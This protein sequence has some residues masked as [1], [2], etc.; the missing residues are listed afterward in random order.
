MAKNV[1]LYGGS[2][3]PV[4]KAHEAIA[5][6]ALEMVQSMTGEEHELWFL[7]AY[8]DAFSV[9]RYASAHHRLNML[10]IITDKIVMMNRIRV[11]SFEIDMANKAGTYAVVNALM[12]EYPSIN[13]KYLI[14]QDQAASIRQWRNS[15]D[16][17]KLLPFVVTSRKGYYYS[18]S[19]WFRQKPHIYLRDQVVD[20]NISSTRTREY[21]RGPESRIAYQTKDMGDIRASIKAYIFEHNL[22]VGEDNVKQRTFGQSS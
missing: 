5:L 21:L 15:R 22:Y 10:H 18:S 9:K 2:F 7:P 16:L 8:S 20:R 6:H 13:F 3:D 19:N 11:C 14:G 4:H 1:I 17:L 12:R